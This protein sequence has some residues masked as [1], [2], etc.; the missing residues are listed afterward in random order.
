MTGASY[1]T[2]MGPDSE[3]YNFHDHVDHLDNSGLTKG[4]SP[5]GRMRL[6]S[7]HLASAFRCIDSR[8]FDQRIGQVLEDELIKSKDDSKE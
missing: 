5:A 1:T 7:V 4:L 8:V 2:F 6:L 3:K